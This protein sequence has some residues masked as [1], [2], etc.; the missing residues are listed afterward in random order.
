[1]QNGT[2]QVYP[3]RTFASPP[4]N[5]TG[6]NNMDWDRARDTVRG[7]KVP[8]SPSVPLIF[9]IVSWPRGGLGT[10]DEYGYGFSVIVVVVVFSSSLS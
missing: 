4:R 1:M 5:S 8:I 10:S 2:F 9:Y 7:I 6:V 3:V